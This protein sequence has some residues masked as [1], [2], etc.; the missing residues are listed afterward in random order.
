MLYV[1]TGSVAG[2]VAGSASA[3]APG[4]SVYSL[5]SATQ[6]MVWIYVYSVCANECAIEYIRVYMLAYVHIYMLFKEVCWCAMYCKALQ[7]EHALFCLAGAFARLHACTLP[8]DTLDF[9]QALFG[10][11]VD[12]TPVPSPIDPSKPLTEGSRRRMIH[13]RRKEKKVKK[14]EAS[15]FSD[16][17]GISCTCGISC[18]FQLS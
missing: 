6:F 8:C 1:I 3:P 2:S 14:S 15:A 12:K 7:M 17:F 9:V 16:A 4:A 10:K 11:M 5:I 13:E 18:M